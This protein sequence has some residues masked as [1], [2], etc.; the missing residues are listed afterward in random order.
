MRTLDPV[1]HAARG[2]A[3]V[4]A[5]RQQKQLAAQVST[6]IQ[7]SESDPNLNLTHTPTHSVALHLPSGSILNHQPHPTSL[8][9]VPHFSVME[10]D[11]H[12]DPSQADIPDQLDVL[13]SPSATPASDTPPPRPSEVVISP[14]MAVALGI[15]RD[16]VP[17]MSAL[18]RILDGINMNKEALDLQAHGLVTGGMEAAALL[19]LQLAR[20]ASKA[21]SSRP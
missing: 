12:S 6:L 8:P 18:T 4:K 20:V 13:P 17:Q 10:V 11:E 9:P 15:L 19:E 2:P 14:P 1:G 5:K 16:I 21:Q 7:P 3:H